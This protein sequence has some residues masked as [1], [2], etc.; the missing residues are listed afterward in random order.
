MLGNALCWSLSAPDGLEMLMV[1]DGQGLSTW[2]VASGCLEGACR[3]SHTLFDSS[4]AVTRGGGNGSGGSSRFHG[5]WRVRSGDGAGVDPLLEGA[6]GS[7]PSVGGFS[8][9]RAHAI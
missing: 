2:F 8:R 5:F 4:V 1:K 7:L 9:E 3:E 6:D